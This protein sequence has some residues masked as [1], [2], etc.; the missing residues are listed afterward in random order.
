MKS[1]LIAAILAAVLVAAC[2]SAP[3]QPPAEIKDAGVG[4]TPTPPKPEVPQPTT[5]QIKPVD[6]TMRDEFNPLKDY[7]I[8][9]ELDKYDV[10]DKYLATVRA[11]ANYMQKNPTQRASVQGNTDERGSREYNLS[12]GQKRAEAVKRLLVTMGARES[13]IEAVSFGEEKPKSPGRD[14]A[15]WAENRRADITY[16]R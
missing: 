4:T 10:S 7:S 16:T 3:T 6:A 5:G 2:S 9:F 1:P 8:Y 14:E 15:A 11:H 12:L 13:Q